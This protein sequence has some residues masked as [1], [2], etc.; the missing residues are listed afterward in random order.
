MFHVGTL[1]VRDMYRP[2]AGAKMLPG[3][4]GEHPVLDDVALPE[5]YP[6]HA[7]L[8]PVRPTSS[9]GRPGPRKKLDLI[10]QGALTLR[11]GAA[12]RWR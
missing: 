4:A 10:G 11:H 6:V 12:S 2:V 5:G 3:S 1:S 7:G 9:W 8:S